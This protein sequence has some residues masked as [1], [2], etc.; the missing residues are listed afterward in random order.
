MDF[1][2]R[3]LKNNLLQNHFQFEFLAKHYLLKKLIYLKWTS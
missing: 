3:Y 1:D 2:I